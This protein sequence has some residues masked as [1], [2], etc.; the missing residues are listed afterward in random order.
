MPEPTSN[1]SD[2]RKLS[3]DNKRQNEISDQRGRLGGSQ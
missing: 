1:P 2:A 3:E